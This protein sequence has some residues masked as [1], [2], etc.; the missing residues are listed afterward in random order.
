MGIRLRSYRKLQQKRQSYMA[1]RTPMKR[2][3]LRPS[4]QAAIRGTAEQQ[5]LTSSSFFS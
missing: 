5:K 4:I 2:A 3:T 1:R